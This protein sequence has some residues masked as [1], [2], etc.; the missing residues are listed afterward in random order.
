MDG[1]GCELCERNNSTL[2]ILSLDT[3]DFNMYT[4]DICGSPN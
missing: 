1:H 4:V 3:D 2:E